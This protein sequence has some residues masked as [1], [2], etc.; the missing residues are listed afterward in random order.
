MTCLWKRISALVFASVTGVSALPAQAELYPPGL[1]TPMPAPQVRYHEIPI[2]S[3]YL[4]R[5]W[6][7]FFTHENRA[8]FDRFMERGARYSSLVQDILKQNGVPPEMYYLGMIESGYASRA[9][10]HARAVG[11]WQ[12]MPSTARQYG[13][14]VDKEVDERLDVI[15]S[16]KAAAH[17]LRDLE[18]EFG[19]WYLA[20]AAYNCGEGR[21][22]QAIRRGRSTDFWSLARR[23][24]LPAETAQYIPKFQAA[25]QIARNPNKYGF[26]R[27]TFYEFPIMKKVRE[28]SDIRLIEVARR[29][30]ISIATLKALNPHLTKERTPR[31]RRGYDLWVPASAKYAR[32]GMN[33]I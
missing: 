29:Q 3:N 8:R 25:M 10:S 22:H 30:R 17:Y 9:K 12:F 1:L 27:K 7:Y 23:G 26:S 4:V 13:L 5:R 28:A 14:R 2:E 31:A 24:A 15:R 16:T 32:V 33:D 6:M 18:N 20:M 19:S 11:I 21:V